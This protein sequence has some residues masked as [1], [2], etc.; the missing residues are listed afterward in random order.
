MTMDLYVI[1]L[2]VILLAI[3]I[4]VIPLVVYSFHRSL[5]TSMDSL[6]SVQKLR[7]RVAVETFQ[8]RYIKKTLTKFGL[9]NKEFKKHS[10][11]MAKEAKQQA[12]KR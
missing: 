1:I 8:E 4:V 2:G 12:V 3:N 9:N 5:K 11:A 6:I 10:K 7:L